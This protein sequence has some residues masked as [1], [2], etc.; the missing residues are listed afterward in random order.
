M[1]KLLK[2]FQS[3]LS[4]DG[5]FRTFVKSYDYLRFKYA[6]NSRRAELAIMIARACGWRVRNGPFAGMQIST[7]NWWGQTDLASKILGFYEAEVLSVL[8]SV[9]KARYPNFLDFGAADG[10]Y[11]VGCTYSNLFANAY[12]FEMSVDGQNVIRENAQ[13]NQM[14]ERVHIFGYAD[15]NFDS[16]IPTLVLSET[17]VLIDI[18][19]G[20]FELLNERVL[21]KLQQS[22]LIVE[23]HEFMVDDGAAK[24]SSLINRLQKIYKITWLKTGA[25]DLSGFDVLAHLNDTDRW[26]ICSEGRTQL[27]SWIVCEPLN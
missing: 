14:S 4:Q 12:A 5:F 8:L 27:Q 11:A 23:L 16:L 20:E 24:L 19:G 21:G 1:I 22:I 17:V 9:D 18:E 26:L 10:Y 2:K 7:S 3:A 13:I 15:E 25:R 6:I